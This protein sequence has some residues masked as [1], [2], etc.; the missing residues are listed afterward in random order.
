MK[1]IWNR[2]RGDEGVTL[3]EL[4]V[5]ILLLSLVTTMAVTSFTVIARSKTQVDDEATGLADVRKVSER[6]GRD[7]RN[8]RGVDPGAT[9]SRLVL[10]IDYNS[11]YRRDA[12]ESVEWALRPIAGDPDHFDVVRKQGSTTQVVE[13][14]S[15]VSEIAF[16]YD[17]PAP[18]TRLVETALD[19]DAFV[20]N[21]TTT[22]TLYFAE[23]LRNVDDVA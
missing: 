19:Y 16:T 1:L 3:V 15:L 6:L 7:I 17:V 22:R 14:R 21:G 4:M 2:L 20:G 8:A 11:D 9:P 18:D 13:A 23:R 5:T 10:W 12:S